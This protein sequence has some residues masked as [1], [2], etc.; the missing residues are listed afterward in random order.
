MP[1]VG[2]RL[3][4]AGKRAPFRGAATAT[5]AFCRAAFTAIE[6]MMVI[7]L[8]AVIAAIVFPVREAIS[9]SNERSRCATNLSALGQAL[10]SLRDDYH[11]F[12]R[13]RFEAG[14]GEP[15]IGDTVLNRYRFPGV[16]GLYSLYYLTEYTGASRSLAGTAAFTTDSTTVGG[17]GTS[18]ATDGIVSGDFICLDEDEIWCEIAEVTND[19]TI[20]LKLP[21]PGA[22]GTGDYTL[23]KRALGEQD[24][25][26]GGH[27]LRRLR[28]LHCPAN[29]VENPPAVVD[30][31]TLGGYN[32]YDLHYRRDWFDGDPPYPA[33]PS[34][35]RNLVESAFP[36]ADTLI[37]FCPYHRRSG[38][39]TLGHPDRGDEDLVL[40]AD[41]A[42]MRLPS[43]PYNAEDFGSDPSPAEWFSQQRAETEE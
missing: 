25:F 28:P 9:R 34:D 12:P 36:P 5:P 23:S 27:Y 22:G 18:W 38:D 10:A 19:T 3:R 30:P 42:V 32:N 31:P 39:F 37:T 17:S 40:F 29:P 11:A 41:G 4:E 24:W 26:S 20:V 7:A 8:A 6:L 15:G 2:R 14:L 43:Y 35:R 21:Y 13:D 1:Y 33:S 16:A